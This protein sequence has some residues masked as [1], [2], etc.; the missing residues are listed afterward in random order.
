MPAMYGRRGM[1]RE[2]FREMNDRSALSQDVDLSLGR[3][4]GR[5]SFSAGEN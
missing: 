1:I 3:V 5:H 4:I 2:K